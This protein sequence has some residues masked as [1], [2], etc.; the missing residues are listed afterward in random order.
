MILRKFKGPGKS[1]W[2]QMQFFLCTFVLPSQKFIYVADT[3]ITK[4]GGKALCQT[5]VTRWVGTGGVG[6]TCFS[7]S[8]NKSKG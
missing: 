4:A 8:P 5:W 2:G 3:Q 6:I 1:Y 7:T